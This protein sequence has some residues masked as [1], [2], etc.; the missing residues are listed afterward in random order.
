MSGLCEVRMFPTVISPLSFLLMLL[1]TMAHI[2][3]GYELSAN[4]IQIL[5]SGIPATRI[6]RYTIE[7]DKVLHCDLSVRNFRESA[8]H[9]RGGAFAHD[10]GPRFC[11]H[12]TSRCGKR[13]GA[14][15]PRTA[16]QADA[17]VLATASEEVLGQY[18]D[19]MAM[20]GLRPP[21]KLSRCVELN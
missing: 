13:C 14:A 11:G 20:A 4:R 7:T 15:T 9:L 5:K 2:V 16:D 8:M 10:S 17:M 18:Q 21:P 1:A 3:R 12:L 6:A 19:G